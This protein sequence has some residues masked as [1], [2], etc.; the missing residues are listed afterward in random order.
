MKLG[1]TVIYAGEPAIVN[2]V[3]EDGTFSLFILSVH[4]QA[5]AQNVSSE[6]VQIVS[7]ITIRHTT[8]EVPVLEAEDT[9]EDDPTSEAVP[10]MD[11][12]TATLATAKPV[13][14][15]PAT[16]KKTRGGAA[17]VR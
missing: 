12:M 4:G 11:A 13:P 2:Q 9:P 17:V 16:A 15:K 5:L 14:A 3:N 1:T 8:A 10:V 6:D 7:T